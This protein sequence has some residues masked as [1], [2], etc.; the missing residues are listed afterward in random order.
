M[1]TGEPSNSAPK[2]PIK[3]AECRQKAGFLKAPQVSLHK[4]PSFPYRFPDGF[5]TLS[6]VFSIKIAYSHYSII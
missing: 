2:R 3:I 4:I 5:L 1:K 6:L